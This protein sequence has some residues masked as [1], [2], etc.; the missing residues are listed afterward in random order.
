MDE[1]NYND[2]TDVDQPTGPAVHDT[3]NSDNGVGAASGH[4]GGAASD[5]F[6]DHHESDDHDHVVEPDASRLWDKLAFG[7]KS[8]TF[9]YDNANI[10]IKQRPT[11]EVA[12]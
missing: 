4:G 2:G 7:E 1:V 11:R 9:F 12:G 8:R 6:V 3:T 10:R 5:S